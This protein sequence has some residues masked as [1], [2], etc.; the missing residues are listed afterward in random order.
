MALKW[1]RSVDIV[2]GGGGP[3]LPRIYLPVFLTSEREGWCFRCVGDHH[4]RYIMLEKNLAS[5]KENDD[6]DNVINPNWSRYSPG[7][8]L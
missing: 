2:C 3:L 1:S 5:M 8:E 6:R 4:D 7:S